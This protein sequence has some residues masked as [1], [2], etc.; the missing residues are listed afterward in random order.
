MKLNK[1]GQAAYDRMERYYNRERAWLDA[2]PEDPLHDELGW[3]IIDNDDYVRDFEDEC[4][5]LVFG[6]D[7]YA[8]FHLE[9]YAN[10]YGN[11][12]DEEY[13]FGHTTKEYYDEVYTYFEKEMCG[14]LTDD[15]KMHDFFRISK[16]EFL[17]SYSYL[18]E[19]EYDMTVAEIK[20]WLKKVEEE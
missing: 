18:T 12:W 2:H 17:F 19:E 3:S 13:A 8:L 6:Y 15:E 11:G 7:D 20:E 5:L 9:E 1:K 10:M 16:E 14:F 4:A